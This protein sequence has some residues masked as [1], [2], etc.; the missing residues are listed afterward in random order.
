MMGYKRGGLAGKRFRN[1][2]KG[3]IYLVMHETVDCTDNQDIPVVVY[4]EEK[5]RTSVWVKQIK[6]F[7]KK[8]EPVT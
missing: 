8:N 4:C 3:T 5:N 6:E 7:I 2:K 1:I